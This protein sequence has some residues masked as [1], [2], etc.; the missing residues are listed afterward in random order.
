M[1]ARGMRGSVDK[2]GSF[3]TASCLFDG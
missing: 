3:Y 1:T 2:G